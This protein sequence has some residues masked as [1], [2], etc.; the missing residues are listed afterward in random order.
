MKGNIKPVVVKLQ[1]NLCKLPLRI[2][3]Q[4]DC[5]ESDFR[6]DGVVEKPGKI[7]LFEQGER[8]VDVNMFQ[9]PVH[10]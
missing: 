4:G 3:F 10:G 6:L 7:P 5:V 2:P 1:R 9:D 8:D